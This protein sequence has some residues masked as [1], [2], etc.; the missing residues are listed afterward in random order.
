M[1]TTAIRIAVIIAIIIVMG[2]A[3]SLMKLTFHTIPMMSGI[4]L[5]ITLIMAFFLGLIIKE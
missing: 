2:V 5:A 1:I 3:I 4:C